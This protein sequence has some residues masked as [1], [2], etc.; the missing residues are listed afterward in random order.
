MNQLGICD[1][2]F[3]LRVYRPRSSTKAPRVWPTEYEGNYTQGGP[4]ASPRTAIFRLCTV[5]IG[6]DD[7]TGPSSLQRLHPRRG[8]PHSAK[9]LSFFVG[10]AYSGAHDGERTRAYAAISIKESYTI[11]VFTWQVHQLFLFLVKPRGVMLPPP[12]Q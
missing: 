8:Q 12:G 11:P 5:E 1:V 4:F 10:K 9:T 2:A 3:I 7:C 6:L